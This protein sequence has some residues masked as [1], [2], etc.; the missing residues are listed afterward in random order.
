MCFTS[1]NSWVF[2]AVRISTALNACGCSIVA[3]SCGILCGT[4]QSSDGAGVFFTLRS[5]VGVRSAIKYVQ[6]FRT[7]V[8]IATIRIIRVFACTIKCT[9]F[10][11][12]H[13][14]MTIDKAK[15]LGRVPTVRISIALHTLALAAHHSV[16][17]T[18]FPSTTFSTTRTCR[19]T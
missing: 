6:T 12:R 9:D 18:I 4:V 13:A 19:S 17:Q 1:K 11:T 2:A 7:V 3:E 15:R 5:T 16:G 8:I 14:F 10:Q